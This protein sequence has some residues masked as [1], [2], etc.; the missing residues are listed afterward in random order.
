V[1]KNLKLNGLICTAYDKA[2]RRMSSPEVRMRRAPRLFSC[3]ENLVD[4]GETD[5]DKMALAALR[6]IQASEADAAQ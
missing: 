2:W 6:E 3:I 5:V 1:R 4:R